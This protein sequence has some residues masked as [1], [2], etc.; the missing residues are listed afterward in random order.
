M[1]NRRS[2]DACRYQ[3]LTDVVRHLSKFF[4]FFS[5]DNCFEARRWSLC[6]AGSEN[7]FIVARSCREPSHCQQSY[8]SSNWEFYFDSWPAVNRERVIAGEIPVSLTADW[9]QDRGTIIVPIYNKA[10]DLCLYSAVHCQMWSA[11]WRGRVELYDVL[12]S[13]R[14]LYAVHSILISSI[15]TQLLK[16]LSYQWQGLVAE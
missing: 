2:Y 14:P 4:R 13:A 12:C 10:E 6:F 3:L 11:L 1:L 5:Q 9:V 7:N 15:S 16:P 8:I